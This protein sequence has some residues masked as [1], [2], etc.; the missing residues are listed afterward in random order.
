MEFRMRGLVLAAGLFL[1]KA[2]FAAVNGWSALGPEGGQIQRIVYSPSTPSKAY[3][4]SSGGFSSSQDGGVTWR[5]IP[6]PQNILQDVAV[7]PTDATRVYVVGQTPPYLQMSTDGGATLSAVA[8]FPAM[9]SLGGQVQVSGDGA[10][11]CVSALLSIA[12]STDRGQ[13][14]G[15][16]TSVPGPANARIM[17]LLMDPTNS[18][19]LYASAVLSGTDYGLFV[20]HD[21]AR[22]WQQT[23]RV[24]RGLPT[25]AT[26]GPCCL[27]RCR[28]GRPRSS[29][30]LLRLLRPFS[31]PRGGCSERRTEEARG[32]R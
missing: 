4:V 6:N 20:T 7:D 3:M 18:N 15:V 24:L 10:T 30:A 31:L 14:W 5:T 8:S 11:V 17:K 22:T 26:T 27:T 2:V 19:V 23:A 29:P 13:T 21:G 32:V 9:L 16:R 28:C 25:A 1:C 12:C